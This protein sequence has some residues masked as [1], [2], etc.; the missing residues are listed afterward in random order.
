MNSS[1]VLE[2]ESSD[3]EPYNL[4][5]FLKKSPSTKELS[6]KDAEDSGNASCGSNYHVKK[7]EYQESEKANVTDPVNR[8]M[9]SDEDHCKI[10]FETIFSTKNNMTLHHQR[11]LHTYTTRWN[12]ATVIH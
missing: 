5:D 8:M 9:I 2:Q 4:D 6:Q 7:K 10:N 12:Y 11:K 3:D 1:T